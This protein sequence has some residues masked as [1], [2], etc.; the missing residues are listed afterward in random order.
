MTK[1][2][3]RKTKWFLMLAVASVPLAG[4]SVGL[5]QYR[6]PEDGRALDASNRIGSGGF[7][8]EVIN[9]RQRV[10]VTGNQIINRNVSGGFDFRGNVPYRDPFEFRGNLAGSS[11]DRFVRR[12]APPAQ[13]YTE[14]TYNYAPQ[15]VYTDSRGVPPPAGFVRSGSGTFVPQEGTINV[16]RGYDVRLGDPL[17][18]SQVLLPR[19]GELL[20]PGQVDPT[21]RQTIYAA[22][23]IYGVRSM[24]LTTQDRLALQAGANPAG[25]QGVNLGVRRAGYDDAAIQRMRRELHSTIVTDQQMVE[26]GLTRRSIDAPAPQPSLGQPIDPNAA[27]ERPGSGLSTGQSSGQRRPGASGA[28]AAQQSSPDQSLNDSYRMSQPIE[29]PGSGQ[30]DGAVV[31]TPLLSGN[32]QVS[33]DLSANAVRERLEAQERERLVTPQEQSAQYADMRRRLEQFNAGRKGANARS[34]AMTR[35]AQPTRATPGA[36]SG[37]PAPAPAAPDG[38]SGSPAP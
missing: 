20:L 31:R 38:T 28:R 33:N 1:T 8:S 36:V 32:A 17:G 16:Q 30:V 23:P 29:A 5:A 10:L 24:D 26:Q 12:S 21:A 19:P 27:A 35:L 25:A 4:A 9:D 15:P 18:S 2:I 37:G 14:Q 22:S 11:I 34:G 7:N 13:R 6:L 3:T